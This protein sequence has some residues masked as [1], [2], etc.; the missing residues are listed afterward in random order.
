MGT[1][2][3]ENDLDAHQPSQPTLTDAQIALVLG[4]ASEAAGAADGRSP[5]VSRLRTAIETMRDGAMEAAP[6]RLVARLVGLEAQARFGAALDGVAD[7]VMGAMR[8]I[9]ATLTYDSRVS[10][11][12]AGFRGTAGAVQ[13]VFASEA[14]EVHLHVTESGGGD[15]VVTCLLYTSPSPRD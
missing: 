1:F 12:L 10:P 8:A 11:A 15:G 6:E 7:A 9:V 3:A 14:G 13:L 4:E 2:Q 5:G